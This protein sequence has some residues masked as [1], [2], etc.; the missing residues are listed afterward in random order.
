LNNLYGVFSCL[1]PSLS[2]SQAFIAVFAIFLRSA[3]FSAEQKIQARR[4]FT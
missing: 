1:I 4:A 2:T 3:A